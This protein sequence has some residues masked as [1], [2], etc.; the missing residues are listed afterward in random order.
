MAFPPRPGRAAQPQMMGPP[1]GNPNFDVQSLF[2][3]G[4]PAGPPPGPPGGEGLEGPEMEMPMPAGTPAPGMDASMGAPGM[5]CCPV[6]PRYPMPLPMGAESAPP[7]Q[8][9]NS[10]GPALMALKAKLGGAAPAMGPQ[11]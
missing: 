6:P 4:A 2:G 8:G 11:A 5:A 7:E 3:G 1:S 10:L 9:L